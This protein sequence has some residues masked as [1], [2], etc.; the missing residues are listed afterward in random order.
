MNAF[1]RPRPHGVATLDVQDQ[2][3]LLRVKGPWNAELVMQ[4]HENVREARPQLT[5]ARWGMMVI[6]TGSAVFGP[7]AMEA[8]RTAA[9]QQ[10]LTMGRAATAWVIAPFVEGSTFMPRIIQGLY[11]DPADVRIFEAVP[12][13]MSWLNKRIAASTQSF[14]HRSRPKEPADPRL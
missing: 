9:L 13:A 6:V 3:V 14:S 11:S 7:D 5:G 4:I 1:F 12:S 10:T 8:T 2:I